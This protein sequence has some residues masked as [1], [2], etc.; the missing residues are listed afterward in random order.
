MTV[1]KTGLFSSRNDKRGEDVS[2]EG[3]KVSLLGVRTFLNNHSHR[4]QHGYLLPLVVILFFVLVS[5]SLAIMS[6][7]SGKYAKTG[8]DTYVA[9]AVYVAEAGVSD[10]INRLNGNPNFL[11]YPDGARIQFYNDGNK[12]KAEYSTVVTNNNLPQVTIESTGYLYRKSTDATPYLTKKIKVQVKKSQIPVSGNMI[13]GSGGLRVSPLARI[14]A[15]NLYSKGKLIMDQ[16]SNIGTA[17]EISNIQVANVA[18]G[19]S[20]NWPQPCGAA[21]PPISVVPW[22]GAESSMYGSVCATNQTDPARIFPGNGGAGLKVGCVAPVVEATPFDKKTFIEGMNSASKVNGSTYACP[23]AGMTVTIPANTWVVGDINIAPAFGGTDCVLAIGGDVYIEG[24]LT[25]GNYGRLKIADSVTAMPKIVLSGQYK[26]ANGFSGGTSVFQAN[27]SG[28]S[29]YL[30][31]FYSTNTTCS[32]NVTIPSSTVATC[33]TI[34]EAQASAAL[35]SY[36]D[37]VNGAVI[38]NGPTPQDVSGAVIYAYYG[39]VNCS[40]GGMVTTAIAAQG[41]MAGTS[42]VN[43]VVPSSTSK[44][45]GDLFKETSY[46]VSDYRQIY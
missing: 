18:C 46:I 34:A 11:G 30:I 36:G 20:T 17:T 15:T 14:N 2:A 8:R 38:C 19:D 41:F 24:T 13:V 22:A 10:T 3:G 43:T 40:W 33:L 4:S 27:S 44:P 31:S 16:N 12:G 35:P 7:V 45:F 9:N 32:K 29:A 23:G 28:I 25:I 26:I 37:L 42:T 5:S 6:V 21:S 39:V 1:R